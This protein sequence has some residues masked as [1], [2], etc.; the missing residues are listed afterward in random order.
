MS[1]TITNYG[2]ITSADITVMM[3]VAGVYP[4]PQQIQGFSVD[5]M[6]DATDVE[7]AEIQLGVD[8]SLAAG[9]VPYLSITRFMVRADSTSSLFFENWL[10]AQN[11]TQSIYF[12]TATVNIPGIKRLYDLSGGV[13]TRIQ[14]LPP[15]RK[16]LQPR[17]FEVT[18]ASVIA[19]SLP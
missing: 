11:A 1:A 19:A 9:W 8:N 5:D 6:F 12:A 16:T 15:A 17:P 13:M 18:W 4:I 10:A 2:N 3:S 7:P 14:P